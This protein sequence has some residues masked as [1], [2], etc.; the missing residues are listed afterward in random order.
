V[1]GG[2]NVLQDGDQCTVEIDPS[3][4]TAEWIVKNRPI[5]LCCLY[6]TCTCLAVQAIEYF[7]RRFFVHKT[8]PNLINVL[9]FLAEMLRAIEASQ[10]RFDAMEKSIS[11][12]VFVAM[13]A[14]RSNRS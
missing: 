12:D 14:S 8:K 9:R 11:D 7:S 10:N 2:N 1:G 13:A 5:R 4:L 3:S 6:C